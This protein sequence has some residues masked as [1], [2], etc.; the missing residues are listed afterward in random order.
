MYERGQIVLVN[1]PFVTAAG[2]QQKVRPAL[3]VS[4]DTG[5]P[6]FPED[7]V[8]A[9]ITSQHVAD[10]TPNEFRV[11]ASDPAFPMHGL[12]VASLVRLDFLMTIPGS[13]V[14]KAIGK[15]SD[16]HVRRVDE[17]LK[18]SLGTT[19][20]VSPGAGPAGTGAPAAV[21]EG[22]TDDQGTRSPGTQSAARA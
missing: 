19:G 21:D 2:L 1:Y 3:V 12:K 18:R 7:V 17:C 20:V 11:E 14:R 15:L 13:L 10:P 4:D 9:A 6:R 22:R 8:L 16:E 5:S